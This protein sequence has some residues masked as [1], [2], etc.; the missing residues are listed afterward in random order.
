VRKRNYVRAD[1]MPYETPNGCV[2]DSGDYARCL[3]IALELVDYPSVRERQGQVNG[4]LLGVGIGSTL[5]S[6]T[7]NFGQSTLL[8][9]E[10]QFSGNNEVA[11]IKLDI[12]GEIVVT[13]GTVP[14]GQGH[15]TTAA[16]V[17]ADILGVSPDE[18]N[19]RPGHDSYWNSHAGF[20]G[21]YASQFA[22]TGLEAV[23]GAAEKLAGE[24]RTIAAAVFGATPD[25]I[26]LEAGFAK[27]K[28]NPDAAIPFMGVGAIVNAN[29]AILPPEARDVT[30]N[31]RYVYV[32]PFQLP[33]KERK[34]GNLTL[35]YATQIHACVVEIDPDTGE[36]EIVD[37]AAVDDCGIRIHPQIV[38]GQVHGATVHALG[39]AL[40]E[41]FAY[42]E[43]GQLLTANFYDYHVPHALDLPE[44]KTGYI[45][46]PSPFSSLGTKGMGEGGGAGIH[47]VCAAIQDATGAIVTDSHNPYR[48]VWQLL[49]EAGA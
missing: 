23:K 11:T 40:W 38:E 4:K 8:N 2:Y 24:I 48:R 16:I 9:P 36:V 39:A 35:T 5:D 42:D 22:V 33:D 14:Q 29:N 18:I 1:E 31:C 46:S 30:L 17:A 3:D 25:D 49:Q 28:Q 44:L 32:P 6:G 15:E 41:T 37:Y 27:L 34:F 43:D 47:A 7:N 26:V 19:V 45:E 12:F 13:L 21:T 10:L 20:S